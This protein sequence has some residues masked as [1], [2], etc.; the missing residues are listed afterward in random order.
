MAKLSERLQKVVEASRSAARAF[1]QEY[2]DQGEEMPDPRPVELPVGFQH[3]PTIQQQI[4]QFIRSPEFRERMAGELGLPATDVESF[5]E[6]NDFEV[7]D[8]EFDDVPTGHEMQEEFLRQARRDADDYVEKARLAVQA[9]RMEQDAS[10]TPPTTPPVDNSKE[11][12]PD[13]A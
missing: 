1:K 11:T 9:R 4:A 6:A 3:A 13:D 12:P 2:N 5:D 10:R 8:D 7:G